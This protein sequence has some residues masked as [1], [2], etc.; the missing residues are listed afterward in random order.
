M[1]PLRS[2]AKPAIS[3]AWRAHL[4]QHQPLLALPNLAF[5]GSDQQQADTGK[6]GTEIAIARPWM[7]DSS[8]L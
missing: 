4:R 6:M 5:T 3:T 7:R 1:L 2:T 8:P